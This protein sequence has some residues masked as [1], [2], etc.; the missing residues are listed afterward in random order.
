VLEGSSGHNDDR[1]QNRNWQT[2][3]Y[4]KGQ[5]AAYTSAIADKRRR[6][7]KKDYTRV[8][9]PS[10]KHNHYNGVPGLMT[11]YS[12]VSFECYGAPTFLLHQ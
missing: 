11:Q 8:A 2:L 4:Y 7:M 3:I 9:S 5:I 12:G 6:K 1:G 10:G